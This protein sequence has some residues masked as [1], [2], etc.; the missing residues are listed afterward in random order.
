MHAAVRY[1]L[2][3]RRSMGSEE[4][5]AD[6]RQDGFA[7]I[8]ELRDLLD[9]H[10]NPTH[11]PSLAVRSVYG[12]W[13]PWLV[14]LDHNWAATRAEVIFDRSNQEMWSA[15]WGA[16]ITFNRPY[17][18]VFPVIEEQY[19]QAVETMTLEAAETRWVG[20]RDTPE[21]RLAE[22]VMVLYWRGS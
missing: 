5:E 3:V 19:R 16:Y 1:G 15:S 12:Q 18:D 11:D 8:P 6:L 14:L 4:S 17:D 13:F 10:L 2:W 21:E 22:H 20:S 9:A 7:R